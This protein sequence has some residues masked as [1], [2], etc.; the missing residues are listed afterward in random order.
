MFFLQRNKNISLNYYEFANFSD[1]VILQKNQ[2]KENK[3]NI[4][5]VIQRLGKKCK[6]VNVMH[7]NQ[8]LIS[9]SA[10]LTKIQK[11]MYH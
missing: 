5:S 10:C 1:Y 2:E 11:C 9:I 6:K 8:S 4:L 3:G 7:M